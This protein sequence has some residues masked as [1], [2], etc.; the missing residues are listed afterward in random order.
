[1]ASCRP[2]RRMGRREGRSRRGPRRPEGYQGAHRWM[3]LSS[4]L[5]HRSPVA[6]AW[7]RWPS[8]P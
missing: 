2:D 6:A 3:G 8:P 1:M 4:R 5:P 7:N